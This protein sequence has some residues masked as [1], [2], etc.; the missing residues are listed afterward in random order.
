MENFKV[1][2]KNRDQLNIRDD[3]RWRIQ[4]YGLGTRETSITG[5]NSDFRRGFSHHDPIKI[6][7]GEK[8]NWGN[9]QEGLQKQLKKDVTRD[10]KR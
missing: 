10:V 4:T 2:E 5:E 8:G 7:D 3:E 9:N 6:P 1:A